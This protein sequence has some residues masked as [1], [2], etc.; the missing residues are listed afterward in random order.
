MDNFKAERSDACDEH[1]KIRSSKLTCM[2]L[3]KESAL[4]VHN[5]TSFLVVLTS[6]FGA[7][8]QELLENACL[9]CKILL[10]RARTCKLLEG[11]RL[12]LLIKH[13]IMALFTAKVD[14]S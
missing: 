14:A 6:F 8:L 11:F 9:I 1:E 7:N 10:L 12:I 5:Y 2:H 3:Q 4:F 13:Q